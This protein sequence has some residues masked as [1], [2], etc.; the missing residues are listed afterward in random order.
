MS[1]PQGMPR[2][3]GNH[4]KLGRSKE[5]PSPAP[6]RRQHGPAH[7]LITDLQPP[8]L[9]KTPFLLLESPS[10]WCLATAASGHRYTAHLA[11]ISP[12]QLLSELPGFLCSCVWPPTA[13]SPLPKTTIPIPTIRN[14]CFKAQNELTVKECSYL[15]ER[16]NKST[17]R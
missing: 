5:G 12:S 3:A 16:I 10:L 6:L 15:H 7:A 11:S 13:A 9:C 1:K 14:F 8:E 4:K 2:T 17:H